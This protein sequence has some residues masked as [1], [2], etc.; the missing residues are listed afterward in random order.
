MKK[1]F[2][3][4][5]LFLHS[6]F[7][8]L[9]QHPAYKLTTIDTTHFHKLP[10]K[11]RT[12]IYTHT[13]PATWLLSVSDT[14]AFLQFAQAHNKHLHI[15][16]R[17]S[18][19]GLYVTTATDSFIIQHTLPL[20]FVRFA[21][22]RKRAPQEEGVVRNYNMVF[23]RIEKTHAAYPFL[24]ATGLTVSVKEQMF[25]TSDIDFANRI[26]HTGIQ[27]ATTSAHAGIIATTI[28]G[29]G[30]SYYTGMGAAPGATLSGADYTSMLPD[31][32]A[33]K[34]FHITAQNHSYGVGI[35]NYY[36]ADAAAYDAGTWQDTVL[37]HVF[38]AGNAGRDTAL[39]GRY[40]GL[41]YVANST[42]SFKMAKNSIAVGALDALFAVPAV[43]SRGPAYDGRIFP[44]LVAYGDEGSSGAAA[45][46]TGS[47]LLLQD[48]WRVTHNGRL[49]AA[50]LVK[51]ALINSATDLLQPGPDYTSGY[52][53]L[54]TFKA[55]RTILQHQYVQGISYTGHTD[56]FTL[57]VPAAARNLRITLAWNDTAAAPNAATALVNDVDIEVIAPGSSQ[58]LQPL[59]LHHAPHKDSLQLPAT[60][61][62]D[63]LNVTEQVAIS[64][65]AAGTYRILVT[66]YKIQSRQ[67]Y[68]V[69]WQWDSAQ[70]FTWLSPNRNS[71]WPSDVI[72]HFSWEYYGAESTGQLSIQYAGSK[73]WHT[74]KPDVTLQAPY[75]TWNAP[76][77][78]TAAVARMQI[79]Q[80]IFYSDTFLLGNQQYPAVGFRCADSLLLYWPEKAGAA[81]YKIFRLAGK[82]MQEIQPAVTANHIILHP[83]RG[84][85]AFYAI[86]PVTG[87]QYT[88]GKSYTIDIRNQ[89]VGCYFYSLVADL[90]P[91]ATAAVTARLGSL[92]QIDSIG[93]EKHNANG[94]QLLNTYAVN[95]NMQYSIR[96]TAL[97]SGL[98][99]Y[100]CLLTTTQGHRI[101]SDSSTVYY[102]NKT[103]DYLLFPNPVTATEPLRLLSN[104]PFNKSVTLFNMQGRR[105]FTQNINNQ[106]EL[107]YTP[108]LPAGM[109]IL[110]IQEGKKHIATRRILITTGR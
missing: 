76:D 15:I 27:A 46:V 83:P 42:G 67:P 58:R 33:Y 1:A 100:R 68:A 19:Y 93:F 38:S 39:G 102:W 61:A 86:A 82:Q 30:N 73:E 3:Y 105:V 107:L 106:L 98:N 75:I 2:T 85:S 91:P 43:S 13:P 32:E 72:Q 108:P 55:V 99:T 95:G 71:Y 49:P 87:T 97:F 45:L 89:G 11:L 8:T 92:Y 94:W 12:S 5:L 103:D 74:I 64:T 28:A 62:R 34:Q 24:S 7:Y 47:V 14:A 70:Q 44:Q 41:P 81:Y 31:E 66:G 53:A 35:E 40:H 4:T 29:A 78:L 104:N 17:L 101:Y 37:M 22:S 57:Q 6:C 80:R 48:A 16:N 50:A 9:A 84:A 96:D 25:D 20:P 60:P 36:G 23:N 26:L 69:A 21:D 88:G 63:S 79:G 56:T 59:V 65:P 18:K 52:G 51:A 10:Y 110:T 109:Y 54:N 90:L 77:T